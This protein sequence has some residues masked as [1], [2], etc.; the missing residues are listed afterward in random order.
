MV[1]VDKNIIFKAKDMFSDTLKNI[2]QG[3]LQNIGVIISIFILSGGYLMVIN[4]FI[5]VRGW[6]DKIPSIILFSSNILIIVILFFYIYLNRKHKKIIS[7]ITKKPPKDLTQ[8]RFVTHL[9]LWW[10]IYE[11]GN[12]IEDFPYCPCCDDKKKL[13]QVEWY[14]DEIYICPESKTRIKL[15]DTVPRKR[16]EILDTLYRAYFHDVNVN[17]ELLLVKEFKRIKTLNPNFSDS[18]IINQ[19]FT[20]TVLKKLPSEEVT[21]LK[22]IYISKTPV[23]LFRFISTNY[24]YYRQ[25][26][27]KT[28]TEK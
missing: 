17:F 22:S 5:S 23:E 20:E 6:I 26:V 1:K 4:T 15:F 12:Y 13:V 9:G 18:E 19:M 10:K 24:Q 16:N 14:P 8:I 28:V 25:Y 3:F 7:E 2:W 11:D 27:N 21:K